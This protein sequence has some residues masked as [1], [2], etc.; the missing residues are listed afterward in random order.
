MSSKLK[1]KRKVTKE[2]EQ[3]KI[4]GE[5]MYCMGMHF[6]RVRKL[7]HDMPENS[8]DILESLKCIECIDYDLCG[9]DLETNGILDCMAGQLGYS[10]KS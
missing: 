5:I 6:E 8:I 10:R 1:I 2:D 7:I 4:F 9:K 3:D